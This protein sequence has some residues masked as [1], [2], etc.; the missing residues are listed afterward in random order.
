M[1]RKTRDDFMPADVGR[2]TYG[3]V[4]AGVFVWNGNVIDEED[5]YNRDTKIW[6]RSVT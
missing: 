3:T 1:L 5:R 2:G 4:V 6:D